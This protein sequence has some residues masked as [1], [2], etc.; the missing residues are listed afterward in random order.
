MILKRNQVSHNLKLHSKR[1][2]GLQD[3]V[4]KKSYNFYFAVKTHVPSTSFTDRILDG[5]NNNTLLD[6]FIRSGRVPS[7][8]T[9]PKNVLD[10]NNY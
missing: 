3:K 6:D 8:P 7:E 10:F 4:F 2:F 5:M 1:F 9:N